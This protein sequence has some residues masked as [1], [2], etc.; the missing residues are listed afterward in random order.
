MLDCIIQTKYIFEKLFQYG[1]LLL[2]LLHV[3]DE[4]LKCDARPIAP[5]MWLQTVLHHRC[6]LV[7]QIVQRI[8]ICMKVRLTTKNCVRKIT[9]ALFI[10]IQDSCHCRGQF[11]F[12][13]LN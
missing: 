1:K 2:L 3:S 7:H 10:I 9:L 8:M 6:P 11:R 4:V 12:Q 13:L 5:H